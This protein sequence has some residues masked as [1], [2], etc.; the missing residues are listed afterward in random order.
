MLCWRLILFS[1]REEC[2]QRD[3]YRTSLDERGILS[4]NVHILRVILL[5]CTARRVSVWHAVHAGYA[6]VCLCAD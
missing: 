1:G 6:F 2:P 5:T 3:L 4:G